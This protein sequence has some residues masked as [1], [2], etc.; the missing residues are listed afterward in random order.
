MESLFSYGLQAQLQSDASSDRRLSVG[1]EW[2]SF[3]RG[4]SLRGVRPVG[5]APHSKIVGVPIEVVGRVTTVTVPSI[6]GVAT[7]GTRQHVAGSIVL[8]ARDLR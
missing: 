8:E 1:S 6:V 7:L 2:P 3:L 4:F 5:F